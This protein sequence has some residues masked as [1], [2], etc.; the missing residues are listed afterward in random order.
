MRTVV[1]YPGGGFAQ[2]VAL[3]F[4]ERGQLQAFVTTLA[5]RPD[6]MLAQVLSRLPGGPARQLAEELSRRSVFLDPG[7][8]AT[9]PLWEILRIAASRL[10]ASPV[11]V[12]AL[13]DHLSHAF[14]ATVARR[15]APLAEAVYA[16]EYTALASF[17]RARE[18]GIRT[19]LDL[20]SMNSR[21]YEALQREERWRFPELRSRHNRYFDRRFE[22]R[23]ARRDREVELA[24]LIVTNS[25]LNMRSHV[26]AG[27]DPSKFV[28]VPLAAPPAIAAIERRFEPDKPLAVLWAGAFSLRKG[29]HILLEA[30]RGLRNRGAIT[31]AV[32]G[33]QLLP[34]SALN[35]AA[36]G[37]S[38]HRS[39]PQ[40]RLFEMF[41]TADV[42]VFPTLS[43]GFG[44]VVGEAFAR[45]LPVITTDQ[46]GAADLV[47]P[48]VNGLVIPAG[49][50][51]QVRTALEWCLD[52]RAALHAMR[53]AALDTARRWQW[54]DYRPALMDAI[55]A[56]LRVRDEA[57]RGAR[58]AISV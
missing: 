46:A 52:N 13:W 9:Q 40:A 2:Q 36:E 18:I 17:E 1:A 24:D 31:V 41:E 48:G 53:F 44:L 58:C 57:R 55:Q 20:P 5:H 43:D 49:E 16:Y 10:R 6:G 56:K 33:A 38:F 34:A 39:L 21:A 35:P 37:V 51:S 15:H 19:L 3:A 4:Q 54:S 14:D 25:N 8:V 22:A 47:K 12:D 29:A 45:G 7:L 26:A 30:L 27:A 23:Q 50:A 28:V 11:L 42:L 32:Y